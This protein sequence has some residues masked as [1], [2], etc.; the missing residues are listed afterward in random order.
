[1]PKPF[2]R[3]VKRG[4]R[5]RTKKLSRGRY[6]KIAYDKGGKSHAGEVHK[7]KSVRRKKTRKC[8]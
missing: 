2:E 6:I 5:V 4:A 3:A 1:M 8:K 7:K